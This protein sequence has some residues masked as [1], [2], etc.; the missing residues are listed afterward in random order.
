MEAFE[1]GAVVNPNGLRNQIEGAIMMGIGGAL[2]EEVR[3]A[4]GADLRHVFEPRHAIFGEMR[5]QDASGGGFKLDQLLVEP[6][7]SLHAALVRHVYEADAIL[8][9]GYGFA[10]VHVNRALHNRL[11]GLAAKDRPPVMIL[12]YA[13]DK[14]D[15]MAF[16]GD[17]RA[18][19]LCRTLS[20]DGHF[21]SES[22]HA[23]PPV[24]SKLAADGAF[25]VAAP[26]R[27]ALWHAG[28]EN[29]VSRL[30]GI[31]PWLAGADDAVLMPRTH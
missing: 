3:F 16:R 8:I 4:G 5:I 23:S 28:F 27:V 22:G 30:D 12:D 29:A 13:C 6:F 24:P 10:D 31:L 21:F 20:T 14:T 26:H 18:H 9:G 7:H 17:L 1:C 25:E 19:E 11:A 15:P 2:F